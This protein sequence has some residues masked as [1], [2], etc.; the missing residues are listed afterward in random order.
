MKEIDISEKILD[1]IDE[2]E[3]ISEGVKRFLKSVFI[4]ELGREK[5]ERWKNKYKK[6]VRKHVGG[7]LSCGLTI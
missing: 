5:G 2:N 1:K 7:G 3:T 4:F 6:E